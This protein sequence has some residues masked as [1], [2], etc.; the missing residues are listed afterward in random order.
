MNKNTLSNGFIY[1]L[2]RLGANIS[3]LSE[4]DTG[5][6]KRIDRRITSRYALPFSLY[7]GPLTFDRLLTSQ[8]VIS[9]QQR[10]EQ[11]IQ[12]VVEYRY[13]QN[14]DYHTA[15][16]KISKDSG[17][18]KNTILHWLSEKP[19]LSQLLKFLKNSLEQKNDRLFSWVKAKV[20]EWVNE[21]GTEKVSKELHIPSSIVSL[22]FLKEK[23][24]YTNPIK[25]NIL[26]SRHYQ[27]LIRY[28][29]Y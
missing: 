27:D 7:S 26:G 2:I 10:K 18:T 1:Y 24:G 14:Q 13:T 9:I 22:W 16:E 20:G 23:I 15:I 21:I 29:F 12:K 19:P 5:L 11:V 25:L 28:F 8:T 4:H 6:P 3:T 17:L